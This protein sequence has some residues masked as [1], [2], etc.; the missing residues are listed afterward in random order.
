MTTLTAFYDLAVGP[1][2]FDCVTFLVKAELHRRKCGAARLHVVFVPDPKGPGGFR[3]K[4]AFYDE[5]EA[6]WRFWNICVPACQLIGA[7]LTVATDWRQ[8]RAIAG[9]ALHHFPHDWDR[10]TL[11]NRRHLVGDLIAAA[12]AGEAIPMLSAS[13]HARRSV[14]DRWGRRERVTLTL[15][16]TYLKERNSDRDAWGCL[17]EHIR[18]S[19]YVPVVLEDTSYALVHGGYGELNLDLRMAMYQEAALNLQANNGAASLCWFSER[20]YRMFGA[21]VPAD[22]WDGLFVRQGLPLGA[23][24]PWAKPQQKIVYGPTTAKQLI[25]EF[26]A[27]RESAP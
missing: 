1:V 6:R 27:W 19:G 5:H 11:K 26:E 21:G 20:P 8:A 3:D 9:D 16:S 25:A 23:T 22:E 17:A 24:W 18:S 15:R 10:Q 12:K 4:S 7:S 13:K 2:S 14:L